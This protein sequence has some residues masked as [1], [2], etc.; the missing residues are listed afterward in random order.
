[1]CYGAFWVQAITPSEVP[2]RKFGQASISEQ[3]AKLAQWACTHP[4]SNTYIMY[5]HDGHVD[6][7]NG[8]VDFT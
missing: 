4:W 8:H 3:A 1:M 7:H 2:A 5:L 6:L